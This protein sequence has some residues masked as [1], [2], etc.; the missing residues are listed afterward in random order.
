MIFLDRCERC[1]KYKANVHIVKVF[2][3]IKK[4][5]NICE[6]C[7]KELGEFNLNS[8]TNVEN[9]FSLNILGGLLEYFNNNQPSSVIKI[10]DSECPKCKTTYA[11]FKNSG[12]LGC[13]KCYDQFM[14]I[15]DIFIKRVQNSSEHTGKIPFRCGGNVIIKRELSSLKDDLQKAILSEEY[16]KAAEIRDKIKNIQDKMKGDEGSC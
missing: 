16:E 12:F 10:N 15:L 4:E 2:D 7:A 8:I 13:D 14:K 3:G 6:K 11:E 1:N 9:T 5:L